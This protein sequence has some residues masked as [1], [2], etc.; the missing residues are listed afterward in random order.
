[1]KP[2]NLFFV[3]F[4]I[5][6]LITRGSLYLGGLFAED[7]DKMGLSIKGFRVHHW[8]YGVLMIP[9][10]IILQ[11]IPLFA[12]GSGLFIDELT[13]LV[14]GGRDHADNYSWISLIGTLLLSVVV[15][16]TRKYWIVWQATR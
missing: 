14:T 4:I 12:I 1:M 9:G 10:G 13:Y 2:E 5:T 3:I 6:I 7:P 16:I 15:F 11:S 8:M